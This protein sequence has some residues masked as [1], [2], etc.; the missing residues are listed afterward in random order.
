MS[1]RLR[2]TGLS[3]LLCVL[4][5]SAGAF[6][7]SQWKEIPVGYNMP[8]SVMAAAPLSTMGMANAAPGKPT[9]KA[10]Y[11]GEGRDPNRKWEI[12]FHGGGFFTLGSTSGQGFLSPTGTPFTTVNAMPSLIVSSYMFGD[13]ANLA[14]AVSAAGFGGGPIV[15]LDP[16][17]DRALGTRNSGP[18]IGFRLSRDLG[19]HFSGELNFDWSL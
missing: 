16:I 2:P 9:S 14:N 1:P 19:S 7:Q 8:K 11:S 13:G 15:P 10:S 6:A 12:E 17:L 4:V 18:S 3:T 5:I